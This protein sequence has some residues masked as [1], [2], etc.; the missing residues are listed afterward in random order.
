M[1]I[2]ALLITTRSSVPIAVRNRSTWK[3]CIALGLPAEIRNDKLP[4][5]PARRQLGNNIARPRSERGIGSSR[6]TGVFG[7]YE[8]LCMT[9]LRAVTMSV[10]D[11][12]PMHSSS[13]A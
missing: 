13:K 1:L 6:K 8:D 4:Y 12:S 11:K 7:N 2:G 10:G 9:A 3:V 5:L